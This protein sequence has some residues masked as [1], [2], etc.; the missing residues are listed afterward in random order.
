M[1][2]GEPLKTLGE[3]DTHELLNAILK[4]PENLW[5]HTPQ[6][7]NELTSTQ[8]AR[9]MLMVFTEGTGWPNIEVRKEAG[10]DPLQ[11]TAVPVMH[12]LLARHYRAGGTIIRAMVLR[13]PAG[14]TMRSGK[15]QHPS[16]H[17][18][19][20]VYIPLASNS[21]VHN[22]LNDEPCEFKV[23]EAYEINHTSACTV[24]N[25]GE[26]PSIVFVFD[27]VPADSATRQTSFTAT[28]A[29]QA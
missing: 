5:I 13:L 28:I 3:I 15:E 9:A 27:Y 8:S 19:H 1:E 24:V 17:H 14:Q 2:I 21:K 22:S 11:A 26:S 23:G 29:Q 4:L 6:Q 25:N 18:S 7:L 10:W 16:F 20:R 12:S